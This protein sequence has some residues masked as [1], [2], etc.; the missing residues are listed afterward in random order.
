MLHISAFAKLIDKLTD[1]LRSISTDHS[2][3]H[4]GKSYAFSLA[5]VNL[6]NGASR[7]Y[8]FTT[9]DTKQIHF[10]GSRT[11]DVVVSVYEGG[12]STGGVLETPRNQN[13]RFADESVSVVK[14]AVTQNLTGAYLVRTYQNSTP[15]SDQELV[16]GAN[17]EYII[18]IKNIAGAQN[19][20]YFELFWY[21]E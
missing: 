20:A 5:D 21:E 17:T 13:R 10:K 18:E 2:Y 19:N 3:G 6:A 1:G 14:S 7:F 15:D 4:A 11:V 9:E 16:L 8:S 12:S